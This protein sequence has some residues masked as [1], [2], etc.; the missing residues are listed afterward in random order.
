MSGRDGGATRR[1]L[2]NAADAPQPAGGY[3]QAVAVEG[4][5]RMLFVSG[6]VPVGPVAITTVGPSSPRAEPRGPGPPVTVIRSRPTP[7]WGC[8]MDGDEHPTARS[9]EARLEA[10][11]IPE[12]TAPGLNDAFGVDVLL[13]NPPSPNRDPYIRDI[14]RVGRNSREG[15]IGKLIH[16][17]QLYDNLNILMF[18]ANKVLTSIDELTFNLKPVIHDARIFMDK[19][20]TEPGRIISGAVKPSNYK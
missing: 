14:H 19:V 13:V 11:R 7:P 4:Q 16:E 6:Q 10:P 17:P 9:V 15:T 3:A 1:T 8:E 20:A 5:R 18:N 2:F 12:V